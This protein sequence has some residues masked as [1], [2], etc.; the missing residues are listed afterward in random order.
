MKSTLLL[1]FCLLSM[2]G[3]IMKAQEKV[4]SSAKQYQTINT[5]TASTP[6]RNPYQGNVGI[7]TET[8]LVRLDVAGYI[9][10]GSEDP[11]G[12]ANPKPGMLRYNK[13]TKKFQ[14]YV[15]GTNPGWVDLH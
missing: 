6:A 5:S 4:T 12:D 8:P 13:D 15:G 14:G 10:L 9:R 1:S 3:G 2:G 7:G 11:A